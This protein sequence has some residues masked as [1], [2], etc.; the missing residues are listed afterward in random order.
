MREYINE[1]VKIDG[2]KIP[3]PVYTAVDYLRYHD[4]IEEDALEEYC[5]N[6]AGICKMINQI[7]AIKQSCFLLRDTTHSCQSLSDDLYDLKLLLMV[8]LEEKYDYIFDDEWVEEQLGQQ[9]N[10]TW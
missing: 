1:P 6:N 9:E 3:Y 4:E 5:E 8:K 2:R 10:I 7:M